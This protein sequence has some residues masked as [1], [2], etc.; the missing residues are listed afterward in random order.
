MSRFV[1]YSMS[2]RVKKLREPVLSAPEVCVER[3][4]Y[5]TQSY[6]QTEGEVQ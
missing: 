6:M 2:E 4:M 1:N 5:M 3:A